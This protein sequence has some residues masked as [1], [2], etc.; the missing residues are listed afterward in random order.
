MAGKV[1][2]VSS[3]LA[4]CE[5]GTFKNME[6]LTCDDCEVGFYQNQSNQLF[7]YQ[8][9]STLTTI[10]TASTQEDQ[11]LGEVYVYIVLTKK[12]LS[13]GYSQFV[14]LFVDLLTCEAG[15]FRNIQTLTCDDCGFGSYQNQSNQLF[16]YTCPP[17]LI[18][19]TTTATEEDQ[20]LGISYVI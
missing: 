3:F 4:A 7:C 13:V 12:A 11:C 15:K 17:G 20:C 14:L 8:C 18:T 16:C 2:I 19:I 9:P 5:P 10:T 1:N 6:T